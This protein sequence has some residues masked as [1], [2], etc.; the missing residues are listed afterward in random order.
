[1]ELGWIDFSKT[2]RD[3]VLSV[4]QLLQEPGAVDELGIGT[5]RD[6]F[7]NYFFPGTST[8]QTRAKYFL[9]VPYVLQEAG[10]GEHGKEINQIFSWIDQEEK[11]CGI[12]L[13]KASKD[14]VIGSTILP[15]KW[16]VRAPSDIY[17]NGI[18]ELGIFKD[19]D[20]SIKEYLIASLELNKTTNSGRKLGN[21]AGQE[22]GDDRDAGS[23]YHES[24]WHL[25][26][27]PENWRDNLTI[28]LLPEEADF[29]RQQIEINLN[30][31]LFAYILQHNIDITEYE[32]FA[33]LTE[34]I[35][36]DVSEEVEH[37]MGLANDF[38]N[39]VYLARIR[40]NVM[41]SAGQNEK[42]MEEWNI[43]KDNLSQY[44]KVDLDN[45][46]INLK[47]RNKDLMKFL[48]NLQTAFLENNI[49]AADELIKK[50]E[51]DIKGEDRAKLLNKVGKYDSKSWVGGEKLDYR[52]TSA[53]RII[54]D[55]Y[56]GEA[57]V[58]V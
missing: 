24:F 4:I 54:S 31:T 51:K 28:D 5:I 41:L 20:L 27:H 9:I 55:I 30:G 58:N 57:A 34:D 45:I 38:N 42:A 25:P 2:E 26:D 43:Y 39:L 15:D 21:K 35:R 13:M 56:A 49:K 10:T 18:K 22:D 7:A 16:V 8:V 6:A 1:M 11:D 23:F 19:K 37:M 36:F 40:Y 33:S 17:W 32:D 44:V 47:I 14:G 29:L 50:Q 12:Q 46:H 3:K 48:K 52:F 53:K